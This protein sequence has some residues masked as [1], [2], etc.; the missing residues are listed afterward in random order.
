MA[1]SESNV[2]CLPP[3]ALQARL[4]QRAPGRTPAH[5]ATFDIG[6]FPS[7]V[8][9]PTQEIPQLTGVNFEF[10]KWIHRTNNSDL[11][12]V[13]SQNTSDLKILKIVVGSTVCGKTVANIV[14]AQ[15]RGHI[16]C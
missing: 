15:E 3:E 13:R 10:L 1:S 5:L 12:L 11:A 9:P 7:V 16:P 2:H 14:I 6:T 8:P 4:Q